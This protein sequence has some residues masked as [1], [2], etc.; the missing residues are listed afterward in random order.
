MELLERNENR[1]M[2]QWPEETDNFRRVAREVLSSEATFE[3]RPEWPQETSCAKFWIQRLDR[4]LLWFD[5]MLLKLM[6][7]GRVSD[8]ES[9][10]HM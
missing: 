2:W 1:V 6:A 8:G 7:L 10:G 5:Y 3:Q 9:Q 4:I